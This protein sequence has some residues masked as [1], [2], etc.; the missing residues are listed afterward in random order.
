[1]RNR[2]R[3]G[4]DAG[5][6]PSS[7]GSLRPTRLAAAWPGGRPVPCVLTWTSI[8]LDELGR[9][10]HS[11]SFNPADPCDRSTSRRKALRKPCYMDVVRRYGGH[12]PQR[13]G[14]ASRPGLEHLPS[15]RRR[16]SNP[17]ITDNR[18]KSPTRIAARVGK[19][20]RQE[21]LRQVRSEGRLAP[22]QKL[23]SPAIFRNLSF[24]CLVQTAPTTRTKR[25]I[26]LDRQIIR[27]PA[28]VGVI[29]SPLNRLVEIDRHPFFVFGERRVRLLQTTEFTRFVRRTRY[30]HEQCPEFSCFRPVL[31]CTEHS[32]GPFHGTRKDLSTTDAWVP[33]TGGEK[34][35]WSCGSP[36]SVSPA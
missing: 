12:D 11:A 1:M 31:L 14:G 5:R 22:V 8:D 6:Y 18:T 27:R 36:S 23:L 15:L 16:P 26:E 29:P 34:G 19:I 7:G 17:A 13:V 21:K 20:S 25:A 33:S 24:V 2:Y 3:I 10:G 9:V 28:T 35:G 32:I 30:V 4:R